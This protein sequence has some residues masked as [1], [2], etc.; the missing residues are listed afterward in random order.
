MRT[1]VKYQYRPSSQFDH[2][3]PEDFRI[4]AAIQ[5]RLP[6]AAEYGYARA[7]WDDSE[8]MARCREEGDAGYYST[9]AMHNERAFIGL[10]NV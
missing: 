3:T 7:S 9:A 10:G 1:L 5:D 8:V 4:I 2:V 6:M